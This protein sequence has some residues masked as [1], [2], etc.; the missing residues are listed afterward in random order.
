MSSTL[1]LRIGI[2]MVLMAVVAAAFQF[3]LPRVEP[4]PIYMTLPD[5]TLIDQD[6]HSF[7]LSQMRGKVVV[8][9]LIYTHCPDVCPLTTAKMK[10]IQER[11]KAEALNS[12]VQL[13]SFTIDPERDTPEV[14]QR[15]AQAFKVDLANWVFLTG[16]PDQVRQVTKSLSV[17]VERVYIV[18][19]TPISETAL[20]EPAPDNT[21]YLVNHTDRLFLVDRQGNVRALPPGSRTDVDETMPLI[22]QLVRETIP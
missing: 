11:L 7:S 3:V 13:I 16:V 2:G 5:A 8:L 15:F 17:Y 12:Q 4:L 22:R 6:G 9:S 18:R 20:T 21:P 14:I 1:W 10:Q 19:G